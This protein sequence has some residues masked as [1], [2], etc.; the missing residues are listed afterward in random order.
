MVYLKFEFNCSTCISFGNPSVKPS[1][2]RKVRLVSWVVSGAPQV[3]TVAP[4]QHTGVLSPGPGL[5]PGD[6]ALRAPGGS[7]CV[8]TACTGLEAGDL[9]WGPWFKSQLH[10]EFHGV[11]SVLGEHTFAGRVR[12]RD[13]RCRSKDPRGGCILAGGPSPCPARP[14]AEAHSPAGQAW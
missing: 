13:A 6:K 12:T 11:P 9:R 10:H 2:P 5:L 3:P 7:A 8:W 1:F 4:T 14:L